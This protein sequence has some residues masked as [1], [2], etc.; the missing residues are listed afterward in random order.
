MEF[1]SSRIVTP[2]VSSTATLGNQNPWKERME[3]N[4]N[5]KFIYQDQVSMHR[6]L[7]SKDWIRALYQERPQSHFLE[8]NKNV[9]AETVKSVRS[10]TARLLVTMKRKVPW[11]SVMSCK[12]DLANHLL[13]LGNKPSQ[14]IHRWQAELSTC[15]TSISSLQ[16]FSTFNQNQSEWSTNA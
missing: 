5:L 2:K 9:K 16:V 15:E 7:V 14:V 6:K 13:S 1:L 3:L 4:L 12:V 11:V 10:S 8:T